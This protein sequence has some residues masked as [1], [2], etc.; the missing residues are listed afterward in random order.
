MYFKLL[1]DSI[2]NINASLSII[3]NP[4]DFKS[5]P[6]IFMSTIVEYPEPFVNFENGCWYVGL[7]VCFVPK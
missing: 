3:V 2:P 7:D 1:I 5:D 6:G 4:V